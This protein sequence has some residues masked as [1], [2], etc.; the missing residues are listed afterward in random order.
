MVSGGANSAAAFSVIPKIYGARRIF[1]QYAASPYTELVGHD[2]Y[3]R[4]LFLLGYGPLDISQIKIG[5]TAIENYEDVEWELRAG[6]TDDAP[7][8]LYPGSVAETDINIQLSKSNVGSAPTVYGWSVTQTSGP[9]ADELAV[10]ISFPGGLVAFSSSTGSP[11]HIQCTWQIQWA[12]TGT[13]NWT[14]EPDIIIKSTGRGTTA[15]G[16][17]WR[18]QRGQYDVQMRVKAFAINGDDWT[19]GYS[20]DSFWTALRTIRDQAPYTMAGLSVLAVRIRAS[21]QLS[22]VISNL[23]CVASSI[24]PDYD[25][26]TGSWYNRAGGWDYDYDNAGAGA[27]VLASMSSALVRKERL[28]LRPDGGEPIGGYYRRRP[29]S[30]LKS[31]VTAHRKVVSARPITVGGK[32]RPHTLTFKT[33]PEGRLGAGCVCVTFT[34]VVDHHMEPARR[35]FGH[36]SASRE[37]RANQQN[38][39][40]AGANCHD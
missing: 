2:Q 37:A 25:S 32:R 9:L 12:P 8:R 5:D 28:S 4:M 30:L 39:N 35:P 38:Q 26:A 20:A 10:D 33:H 1:P 3:L 15:A 19:Q 7:S 6:F 21:R 18:V 24:L 22:G 36:R 14:Q 27:E 34:L 13:T 40:N 11:I 17:V 29:R 16:H 23:N 31:P